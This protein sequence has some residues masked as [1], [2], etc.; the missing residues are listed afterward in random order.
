MTL[1]APVHH[2]K[3]KAKLLSRDRDMPLHAALDHVAAEEGYNGWS[4]LVSKAGDAAPSAKLFPRLIDGDMVLV[5]A[6][7]G[8]GKTRFSLEL[9]VEAMKQGRRSHFFTLEY[10]VKDVVALFDKIDEAPARYDALFRLDSSDG[11]HAAYIMEQLADAP[12]GT[13]AVV[14]YLQLLDQKR[15]TPP[16]ETQI[17]QLKDFAA[18]KGIIFVFISQIDRSFEPASKPLPDMS[19]IRLPNPLDLALFSKTCFIHNGKISFRGG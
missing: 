5:G 4:L 14:D 18:A 1:S 16:L 10:T 6:R 13:L 19:D 7:P 17:K 8:Q 15:D 12:R 9:A 3:R 11:I 2:L